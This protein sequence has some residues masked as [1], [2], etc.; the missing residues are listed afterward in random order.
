MTESEF[1]EIVD[2]TLLAIEDAIDALDADID[3]ENTSGIL[4]LTCPNDSKIIINRQTPNREI[5]V[6]ARSG[7]YHC[8]RDGEGWT[9]HTTGE[10]LD[11][12]LTRVVNE[13]TGGGFLVGW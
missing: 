10:T 6:A 2:A 7:G 3:L 11:V 8:G 4:T 12:L 13:Q 1:N 5:W 9:C